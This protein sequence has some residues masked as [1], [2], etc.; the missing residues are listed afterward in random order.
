MLYQKTLK[1]KNNIFIV[2]HAH[3]AGSGVL[4]PGKQADETGHAEAEDGD[5]D[6]GD[7]ARQ[8]DLYVVDHQQRHAQIEYGRLLRVA[9]GVVVVS[10]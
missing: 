6:D 10:E 5:E 9:T 3:H 1:R 7:D 8:T 4:Q 2:T